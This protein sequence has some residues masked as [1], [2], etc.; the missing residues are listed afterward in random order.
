MLVQCKRYETLMSFPSALELSGTIDAPD[1]KLNLG[2]DAGKDPYATTF[3][4]QRG[5][6]WLLEIE[7]EESE[8][9]KPL[10]WVTEHTVQ[11]HRTHK[12]ETKIAAILSSLISKHGFNIQFWSLPF[13]NGI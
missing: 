7:E 4:R 1:V 13:L 10:L 11:A 8:D 3:L 9:T 5:Y 2:S 12:I 6:G